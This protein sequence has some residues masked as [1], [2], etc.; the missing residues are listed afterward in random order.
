MI[1]K[2]QAKY[3]RYIYKKDRSLKEIEKHL[4]VSNDK[5][6]AQTLNIAELYVVSSYDPVYKYT[7]SPKGD[8]ELEEYRRVSKTTALSVI[9]AVTGV[10]SLIWLVLATFFFG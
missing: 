8:Y 7:T 1:S 4:K 6:V 2:F 3:L 9:G 5:L 10:A